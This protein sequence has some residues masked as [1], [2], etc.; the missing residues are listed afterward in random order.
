M[1][2]PANKKAVSPSDRRDELRKARAAAPALRTACPDAAVVRVELEFQADPLLAHAPQV[3]SLYPPAKAHFAYACP[4]GDCDGVFD[5]NE[6]VLDV[7]QARKHKTRGT[8]A[9]S[10]HRSS[11]GHGNTPCG[12]MLKYSIAVRH[13][14]VVE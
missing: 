5:L 4:F 12:L 1:H 3:F 13:D 9:C 10:G 2:F 6:V 7:L 14:A 11:Q 8:V